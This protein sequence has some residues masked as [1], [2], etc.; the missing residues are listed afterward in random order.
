MRLIQRIPQ[1]EE[2]CSK[3]SISKEEQ[4]KRENL[5][6]EIRKKNNNYR[7]MFSR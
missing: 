5:L 4:K 2:L 6:S 7:A 1:V 3:Y